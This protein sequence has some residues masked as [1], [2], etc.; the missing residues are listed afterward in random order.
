MRATSSSLGSI[1]VRLI[2]VPMWRASMNRVSP[3]RSRSSDEAL[4][5]SRNHRQTIAAE[6]ADRLK[7]VLGEDAVTAVMTASATE[8]PVLSQYRRSKQEMRQLEEDFKNPDHPLRVVVVK[9]MWLTG[10]DAPVLHTLL[11]R[12]ADARSRSAAG[13]RSRQPSLQGQAWRIVVDYIGIGDDL[14]ASLQAYSSTDVEDVVVPLGQP[15]RSWKRS[16]R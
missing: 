5:R 6:Y 9:N 12:Q 15:P 8:D 3:R 7:K 11:H 14:R 13:H 16:T 2:L 4:F 1:W 10:F